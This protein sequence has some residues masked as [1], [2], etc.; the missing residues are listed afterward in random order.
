MSEFS[1]AWAGTQFSVSFVL[2]AAPGAG[3]VKTE[4]GLT[5]TSA[6]PAAPSGEKVASHA[7]VAVAGEPVTLEERGTKTMQ[8]FD[9]TEGK[10]KYRVERSK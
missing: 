2:Q 9:K 3:S 6:E 4:F 7:P 1:P 8:R 5:E 10:Q